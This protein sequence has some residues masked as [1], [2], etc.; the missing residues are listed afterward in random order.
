MCVA[1]LPD[2]PKALERARIDHRNL[3]LRQEDVTVHWIG[4]DLAGQQN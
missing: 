4:D 1:E 3:E 2:L